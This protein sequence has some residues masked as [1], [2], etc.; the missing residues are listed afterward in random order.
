MKG[1]E[2]GCVLGKLELP[3]NAHKCNKYLCLCHYVLLER[4][5]SWLIVL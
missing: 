5:D 4:I 2:D 1:H 3:G